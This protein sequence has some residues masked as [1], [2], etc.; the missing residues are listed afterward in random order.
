MK[1]KREALVELASLVRQLHSNGVVHRDIKPENIV[2]DVRGKW[3]LCDLDSLLTENRRT[4]EA[5]LLKPIRLFFGTENYFS[6]ALVRYFDLKE[7]LPENLFSEEVY[8]LGCV[9]FAIVH[10]HT[11]FQNEITE[12]GV[13]EKL[14]VRLNLLKSAESAKSRLAICHYLPTELEYRLRDIV[15]WMLHPESHKR[16]SIEDVCKLLIS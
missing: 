8:A 1:K 10:G 15:Y 9:F 11:L 13:H 2:M 12:K 6:P 14:K 7:P 3:K 4:E 5:S 16:P